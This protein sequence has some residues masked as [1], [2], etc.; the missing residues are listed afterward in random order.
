MSVLAAWS[1]AAF[2]SRFFSSDLVE[3]RAQHVPGLRAVLVLRA[4]RLWQTTAMPVGMWVRRTADSVLLTCWPPAPPRAH[5]VDAHVG[6][7]DVDLDA[8]VDHRIDRDAGERGVPPRIGIERRDA[9]QPVH[10]GFGLQPAIG[11]VALDLDG[12]RLDAG[13]FAVGLF[14]ILDLVAVLLGPARV[15]A[16]QH[17][18]PVLALGAAGAGMDFEIGVVGVGLARQQRLEL[19]ARDFVLA[20]FFSAALGLGDDRLIVLGLA[21]LDHADVVVELALDPADGRRADP[22]ARCAPAS[23]LRA[24]ADRSRDWDLRPGVQLGEARR[25]TCRSQRCLLSSPTDCLM[26]STSFSISARMAS[27]ISDRRAARM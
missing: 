5:G 19:A 25:A 24:A 16:Q 11:V 12:R 10:A 18:G 20:A 26:S 7:V 2:S 4:A 13:L 1:A 21:E 22:R 23:A 17:R 3:P 27:L 6:F 15:H 14:Q 9:H 8:V